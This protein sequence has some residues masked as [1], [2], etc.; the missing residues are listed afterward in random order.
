MNQEIKEKWLK[1]LRSNEY[2]QARGCLRVIMN[3]GKDTFCC[4]GVL[5]NEIDKNEWKKCQFGDY[6][7]IY[8][9]S[10]TRLGV[11]VRKLAEIQDDEMFELIKMNDDE[12]L[13]FDQ[14]AD[15]IEEN[16]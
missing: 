14:I 13:G 6:P 7:V 1:A 15:W 5:C 8:D 12:M 9:E 11:K 4:L 2:Q 10:Y 16:L 3:D